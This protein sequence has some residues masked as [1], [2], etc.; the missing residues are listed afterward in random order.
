LRPRIRLAGLVALGCLL[1][2]YGSTSQ[3]SWLFLI[4]FWLWGLVPA[5]YAYALWS[6]RGV[7]ASI[8][9]EGVEPGLASPLA[10]LPPAV[11]LGAPLPA[12]IFEGD[13]VDVQLQLRSARLTR[14]PARLSGSVGG[15]G[16][17]AAVG[18]VFSA[19]WHT[20]RRVERVAR[21][22]LQAGD[23]TLETGDPLGLFTH[24]ETRPQAELALVLPRFTSLAE[25]PLVR[26]TEASVAALRAGP[27]NEL[28]GVREYRPGD[29]LRRI[30]WRS[31]ARRGELV[32]REYEPPGLR[33]LT[34]VLEPCP[35]SPAVAD[36]I[37]RLAASEA[38]DCL[39]AGGRAVLWAPG[40]APTGGAE[41]RSLWSLLEWLARYPELPEDDG[42]SPLMSDAVGIS[43]S[44]GSQVLELLQDAR[45]RGG[46][47]RAWLVGPDVVV[48][49]GLPARQVGTEW[50]L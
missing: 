47:A 5:A 44:A 39:R 21:G 23:W 3:V 36:Q 6:A 8:D 45:R 33:Q 32:V 31:S 9:V 41:S 16:V 10:E 46:T 18:R 35:E 30:H 7:T 34:I 29:P 38:W 17:R 27:G 12:P 25:T 40:R 13:Q 15:L 20:T 4:A 24:V 14:G 22:V 2:V 50:P 49:P 28:F 43:G 19:G 42:V 37:A 11:L 26:E 1:Y 48:P